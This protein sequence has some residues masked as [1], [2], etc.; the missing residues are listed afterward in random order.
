MVGGV[1]F[2]NKMWVLIILVLLKPLWLR[3]WN[4]LAAP[5][6]PPRRENQHRH[7]CSG[8]IP[9]VYSA[10]SLQLCAEERP[11]QT[12]RRFMAARVRAEVWALQLL[13]GMRGIWHR[14]SNEEVK[15][16]VHISGCASVFDCLPS[17][18]LH[19]SAGRCWLWSD[20]SDLDY[21]VHKV[22]NLTA[23]SAVR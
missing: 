11:T 7:Q 9:A 17:K 4:L 21:W 20:S 16:L 13:R 5:N 1:L 18:L 8:L 15:L 23:H 14:T 22:N 12:K 2:S 3:A 19:T 10:G 6:I